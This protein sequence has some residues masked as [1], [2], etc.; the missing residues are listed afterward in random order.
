[1]KPV[2]DLETKAQQRNKVAAWRL[3]MDF[4]LEQRA[5]ALP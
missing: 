5:N 1:M 2:V 4:K 3:P